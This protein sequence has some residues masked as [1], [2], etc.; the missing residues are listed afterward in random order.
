MSVKTVDKPMLCIFI[1]GLKPESLVH[2]PFL[3]SLGEINRIR[4]EYGYSIACHG[5][6][7][8]GMH[9][10]KH[11]LWFVWKKDSKNSPFNRLRHLLKL[12]LMRLLPFK[13]AIHKM[14]TLADRGEN[15]SFFGIPRFVHCR[16]EFMADLDVAEKKNYDEPGYLT[17]CKGLFD[18]LRES[19]KRFYVVGMDKSSKEESEILERFNDH[20]EAD[21]IYWFLGDVDHFSHA[22]GQNSEEAIIR[23]GKL[24]RLLQK[25]WQDLTAKVGD[26]DV[27]IWSD[28]GHIDIEEMIDIYSDSKSLGINLANLNHV[29]DGT[30]LRIWSDSEVERLHL[31]GKYSDYFGARGEHLC[32][33]KQKQLKLY[34]G[35]NRFGDIVF[36]LRPGFAFSRT[37]WGWSSKMVSQHGYDPH[38]RRSDGVVISNIPI[39]TSSK[40]QLVDIGPSILA[41]LGLA[42]KGNVD[43]RVFWR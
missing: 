16:P 28:H 41:R 19:G 14:V 4:G 31:I 43:G 10:S 23:L 7:Y 32:V 30:F 3:S 13:L 11:K 25:K 6:M 33:E 29:V 9:T 26:V 22:L 39:D 12:P 17:E 1:D 2:M 36:A 18:V 37:I 35:D 34:A 5:S 24:D 27:L 42:F 8:S 38:D 21:L 20:K 15:T 40:L